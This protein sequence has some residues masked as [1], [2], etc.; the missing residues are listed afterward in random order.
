MSNIPNA[1][2]ALQFDVSYDTSVL[3]Y[4]DNFTKGDLASSFAY[5]GVS[6][7]SSGQISVV[8]ITTSEIATGSSGDV[9]KLEFT[10]KSC[11]NSTLTLT[12]LEDSLSG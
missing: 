2:S 11:T 8:G 12:G 5:F 1:V 3:D 4:T 7:T 9:V 6:E 10:V